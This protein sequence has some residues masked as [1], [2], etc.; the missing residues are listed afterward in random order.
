MRAFWA[1]VGGRC[2]FLGSF[3][4]KSYWN[5]FFCGRIS[6]GIKMGHAH[7]VIIEDARLS[8]LHCLERGLHRIGQAGAAW[9]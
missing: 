2:K 3:F 7:I 9:Q 5:C 6:G 8:V 1:F 4:E